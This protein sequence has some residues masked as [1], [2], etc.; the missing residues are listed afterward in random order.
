MG[1]LRFSLAREG[2]IHGKGTFLRNEDR[3][4]WND[5]VP[6]PEQRR[7]IRRIESGGRVLKPGRPGR[8]FCIE[9]A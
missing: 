8:L 6:A 7:S 2:G 3:A 4:N 9:I 1:N 5:V